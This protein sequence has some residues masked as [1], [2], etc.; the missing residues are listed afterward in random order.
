MADGKW[1]PGLSPAMP[2]A[3]AARRVLA[4]RLAA[5]RDGL[6]GAL[7]EADRDVEHV[8]QLRVATRRAGAAL[9]IFADC[10]P[11][12]AYRTARKQLRRLRRAAGEA[13]DWDVFRLGLDAWRARRPAAEAPGLD[14][15]LGFALAMRTAAQEQLEAAKAARP[16]VV[17]RLVKETVAA[18]RPPPGLAEPVLADLAVPLLR[19]LL[20]ALHE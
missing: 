14:C 10:L 16:H 18:V 9:T 12:K 20:R 7:H 1:I 13:R 5:V 17:E 19:T 11:E 2:V 15:L 3:E 8:H 4:V 6:P